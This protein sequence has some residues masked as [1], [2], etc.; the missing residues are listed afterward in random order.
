MK[1]IKKDGRLQ[2]FDSSKIRISVQNAARDTESVILN[3]SD[4][5]IIVEDVEKKLQ[6]LRRNDSPTSSYE[7]IGILSNVLVEDGF[8]TVFREYINHV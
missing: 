1:L 4:I 5:K 7:I 6:E 8:E 2:E 3:E